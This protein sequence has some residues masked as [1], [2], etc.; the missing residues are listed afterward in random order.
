MKLKRIN[1]TWS[2]KPIKTYDISASL[3]HKKHFKNFPVPVE[4][5]LICDGKWDKNKQEL[6]FELDEK[7]IATKEFYLI[8]SFPAEKIPKNSYRH[9]ILHVQVD[10][11]TVSI[12]MK[13]Q[14]Y[15]LYLIL[16]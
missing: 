11:G 2:G 15:Y 9:F 14:E 1:L 7:L 8:L 3:Y 10:Y 6:V 5:N 4:A 13:Y 12:R 16:M